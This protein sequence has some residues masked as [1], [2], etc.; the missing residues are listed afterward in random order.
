MLLF[1]SLPQE[2]HMPAPLEFVSAIN[3]LICTTL[4]MSSSTVVWPVEIKHIPEHVQS[5]YPSPLK[6]WLRTD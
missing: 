2:T 1:W 6:N 4:R 5:A 3:K